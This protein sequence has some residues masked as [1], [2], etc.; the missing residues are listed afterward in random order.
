MW[1]NLTD[2]QKLQVLEQ[3]ENEIG[4]PA[5]VVEKDWWVCVILKAVFRSK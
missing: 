1:I 3:V 5:F 2:E 4:L